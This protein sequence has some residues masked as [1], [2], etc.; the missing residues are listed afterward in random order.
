MKKGICRNEMKIICFFFNLPPKKKPHTACSPSQQC[1]LQDFSAPIQSAH[2]MDLSWAGPSTDNKLCPT[3]TSTSFNDVYFQSLSFDPLASI[4]GAA[5]KSQSLKHS[6]FE[7]FC[8]LAFFGSSTGMAFFIT[9][10]GSFALQCDGG[11]PLGS[12]G[13]MPCAT[14]MGGGWAGSGGLVPW[15]GSGG[16]VMGGAMGGGCFGGPMGGRPGPCCCCCCSSWADACCI[17]VPCGCSCCT[18]CGICCGGCCVCWCCMGG[19]CVCWCCM[20]GCCICWCCMGGCCICWCCMGGCCICWCCMGGCCI[21]WCCIGGCCV[22]WWCVGAC[23]ICCWCCMPGCCCICICCICSWARAAASCMLIVWKWSKSGGAGG[24]RPSSNMSAISATV[25]VIPMRCIS[26]CRT[27][28]KRVF[29]ATA[30]SHRRI[31]YPS[32]CRLGPLRSAMMEGFL[33]WVLF[34]VVG[35]FW[36]VSV[37]CFWK[38]MFPVMCFHRALS[39]CY[40]LNCHF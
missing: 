4:F 11:G 9:G 12:G 28:T 38:L 34:L 6:F 22:C 40:S 31:R 35:M 21:C 20:G 24:N 15:A 10:C 2:P 23:C 3:E 13:F 32:P 16:L 14:L 5:C 1:W 29:K 36:Y 7:R 18:C 37:A 8:N 26:H 17:I 39:I 19:R 30:R 27:L 33:R 25:W